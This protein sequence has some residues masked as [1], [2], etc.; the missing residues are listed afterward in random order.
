METRAQSPTHTS[1]VMPTRPVSLVI[2]VASQP[3]VV[4]EVRV[5]GGVRTEVDAGGGG[6]A[7]EVRLGVVVVGEPG[8]GGGAALRELVAGGIGGTVELIAGRLVVLAGGLS[9]TVVTG[10]MVVTVGTVVTVG[11]GWSVLTGVW[12]LMVTESE[13]AGGSGC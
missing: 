12:T 10:G 5:V 11:A 1:T 6:G 3:V 7:V 4:G 2:A 13:V 9:G 8:A